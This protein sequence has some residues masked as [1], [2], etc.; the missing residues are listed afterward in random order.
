[1][2][3]KFNNKHSNLNLDGLNFSRAWCLFEMG[4][5]SISDLD[6]FKIYI[7]K[8]YSQGLT[9]KIPR[10]IFAFIILLIHFYFPERSIFQQDHK[11]DSKVMPPS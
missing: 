11:F 8:Q 10:T 1:M 7:F 3:F 2:N 9:N 5:L 6:R 4:N